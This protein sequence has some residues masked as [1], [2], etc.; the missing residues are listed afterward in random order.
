MLPDSSCDHARAPA[1]FAESIGSPQGFWGFSCSSIIT[2]YT[3][4]CTPDDAAELVLMG[5]HA[6]SR[7][8]VHGGAG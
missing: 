6:N 3:G 1:Y 5:E 2:F 4:M 8:R 7:Y